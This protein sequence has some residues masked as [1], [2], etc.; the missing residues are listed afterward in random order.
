MSKKK[1]KNHKISQN[2]NINQSNKLKQNNNMSVLN[3]T[4]WINSYYF[5]IALLIIMI[6]V[7]IHIDIQLNNVKKMLKE[8]EATEI[9][10]KENKK[11][12]FLGDS[13]ISEY[14]LKKYY[15]DENIIN[16]GI[17]GDTTVGILQRL[18]KSVFDYDVKKVV[19]VIGTNDINRGIDLIENLELIISKIQKH[20]K[21]IEIIL[22]SIYPINKT[23]NSKIKLDMVGNRTNEKIKKDNEQLKKLCKKKNIIYLNVYDQLVDNQ[24]NLKI[25][26]TKEGLHLTEQG[27]R[28][29]TNI[30][31]PYI[32]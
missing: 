26:Y 31:N 5:I 8:Q 30:L 11:I 19:L 1:N 2:L 29:V 15:D 28:K 3:P 24:G 22:E 27:Y 10:T 6:G 21:N 4:Q 18:Q 13:L 23:S 17:S 20:D 16:Q 9:S 14:D 25:E 12:I 32:Q 7:F